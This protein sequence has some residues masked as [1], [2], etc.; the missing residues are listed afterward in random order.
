MDRMKRKECRSR[1]EELEEAY[2][3]YRKENG[4]IE[5][6]KEQEMEEIQEYVSMDEEEW[7]VEEMEVREM[8]HSKPIVPT[9]PM[10]PKQIVM[11]PSS[12][13]KLDNQKELLRVQ[14]NFL[15]SVQN[16]AEEDLGS[17]ERDE[18]S[19][20]EYLSE[21]ENNPVGNAVDKNDCIDDYTE[22]AIESEEESNELADDESK[23]DHANAQIDPSV[24]IEKESNQL[25]KSQHE[26]TAAM[27]V[28]ASICTQLQTVDQLFLENSVEIREKTATDLAVESNEDA[29]GLTALDVASESTAFLLAPT[30]ENPSPLKS[31]LKSATKTMV[32][33]SSEAKI[34]KRKKGS[35]SQNIVSNVAET[36]RFMTERQQLA[37]LLA[38]TTE[39]Q[40]DVDESKKSELKEKDLKEK[41]P[42][43]A[44]VITD[45]NEDEVEVK[46][47]K[48]VLM[49][50]FCIH[51]RRSATKKS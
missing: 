31:P 12:P 6:A 41:K 38:Q 39:I 15:S 5:P 14:S 25:A 26:I 40:H 30:A 7:M 21:V 23:V 48:S 51:C 10:K 36:P 34:K 13:V 37:F 50:S 43:T 27:E 4:N 18:V 3:A 32:P 47:A 2:R 46:V 22:S 28:D 33:S 35:K 8:Q 29:V 17:S 20:S 19:E 49:I 42:K 9:S 24:V 11:D 16:D 45:T 1:L 44:K